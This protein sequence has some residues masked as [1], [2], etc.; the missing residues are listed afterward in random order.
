MPVYNVADYLPLCLE[1][2]REQSFADFE[3]ICVDDGSTDDSGKLLDMT[4]AIDTRFTALHQPN[5]G[6]SSAKNAAL[7]QARGD[8]I[9][10]LDSDDLLKPQA[11]QRLFDA[12]TKTDAEV[13]V[14]GGTPYPESA[15]SVWLNEVL[16]TRPAQFD[17]FS[18]DLMFRSNATPFAW[19]TAC[20]RSF[21][22]HRNLR[23]NE[24]IL[25]G[26]DTVFQFAA[27]PRSQR[28]V[29]IPDKLVGYRVVREGSFMDSNASLLLNRALVHIDIV[30]LVFAD[31]KNLGIFDEYR[32]ELFAWSTEFTLP[33]LILNSAAPNRMRI[34]ATLAAI[35]R[36]HLSSDE[37]TDLATQKQLRPIM[38]MVLDGAAV[39][40]LQLKMA[41]LRFYATNHGFTY[42]LKRAVESLKSGTDTITKSTLDC[43]W[44][45]QDE[46]ARE[47]A[48]KHLADASEH[49]R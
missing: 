26:E 15:G 22:E 45:Q 9:C 40:P 5:R 47:S 13:V 21:L 11:L 4:A 14:Y 8:Y 6:V 36:R 24:T 20:K 12:F 19:R 29:V 27:Y 25:F 30:D 38:Q 48:R 37:L 42:A 18:A 44:M 34:C 41:L 2:V 46:E 1:S 16:T 31:W 32:D 17:S 35:W 23:Y 10:F 39:S 43:A 49:A 7:D 28:T 3:A 33:S